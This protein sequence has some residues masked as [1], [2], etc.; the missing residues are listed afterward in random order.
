MQISFKE[1]LP[2]TSVKARMRMRM[3]MTVVDVFLTFCLL[4][5]LTE[6]KV[7]DFY[8]VKA[9]YWACAGFGKSLLTAN[10]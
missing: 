10:D 5:C 2:E 7:F 3:F 8:N 6:S 9:I 4:L 1:R